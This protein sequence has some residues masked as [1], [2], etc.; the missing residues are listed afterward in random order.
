MREVRA[1]A[2]PSRAAAVRTF[3]RHLLEMLAAMVAGMAVLG[4]VWSL[5]LARLGWPSLDDR[6]LLGALVMVTDM[7]IAMVVAMRYRGHGWPATVEMSVAMCLPFALL[8]GPY[9]MGLLAADSM[10]MA[11]HL[12]MVVAMVAVMLRR[13]AEFVVR[14]DAEDVRAAP[15]QGGR[16]AGP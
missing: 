3:L 1:G 10:M 4:F 13:R 8:A 9:L 7:T 5:V 14:H 2:P 16:P 15:R 6:P 12:L 11:G